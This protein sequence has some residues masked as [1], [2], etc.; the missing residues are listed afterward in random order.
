M[1]MIWYIQ[2]RVAHTYM[3]TYRIEYTCWILLV[4]NYTCI[5]GTYYLT[6][7]RARAHT[8]T[9]T[10]RDHV[11]IAMATTFT[12]ASGKVGTHPL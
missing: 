10:N 2:Q 9:H 1:R 8:H 11:T 6:H 4:N 12:L 5:V 3:Y 7:T